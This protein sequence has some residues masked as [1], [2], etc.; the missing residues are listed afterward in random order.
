MASSIGPLT[1][2]DE[3]DYVE[4]WL[5]CFAAFARVKEWQ[6]ER[7][8]D[9][10]N[11]ITN[12]FMASAGCEAIMKIKVI[13]YP[14]VLEKMTFREIEQA[15]RKDVRPKK[16]LVIAERTKFLSTK[17]NPGE[18]ARNYVHRLKQA[19]RFCEFEKLGSGM[20]STEEELIQLRFIEGLHE[21]GQKDKI[22][23]RLQSSDMGLEHCI[24]FVQQ[25][26]LISNFK[27]EEKEEAMVFQMK[28]TAEKDERIQKKKQTKNSVRC[29]YCNFIH[30]TDRKLNCPAFGKTCFVCNRLNHF[31][32][33]CEFKQK[34]VD[35]VEDIFQIRTNKKKRLTVT[36]NN[37]QFPMQPDTGS[38][39]T[40][41][42][43]NF[44]KKLGYPKLRKS[45]V[46]LRQFDGSCINALGQFEAV[47]EAEKRFELVS[48]TVV[49][50]FKDHGLIGTDI[51]KVDTINLINSV[52]SDK[53]K[54]GV[55]KNYKAT[56]RVKENCSPSYFEARRIPI[57]L[58]PMV[59]KKLE[60]MINQGILEHV[61]KG[62]SNWAS[63]IVVLKKKDG[64]LRICGDY[65]V[66]VNH[67]IC[68]DSYP[69]PNVETILHALAGSKYFTKI[70][71][72]S[73]YNQIQIDENF[74]EITTINTPIGLLRWCRMPYG[75][76]TASSIF[77]RAIENVLT[78]EV[79]KMVIYQDDI[80]VGAVNMDE[81]RRKTQRILKKLEDAGMSI[82]KEKCKFNCESI[83]YLGL[84][85]SKDGISPD[86][87]L[88]NKIA[89]VSTPTN[90]KD[91]ESFLGLV[92]FYSRY[93]HKYSD[94]VEPFSEVRKKNT[95]FVWS[96]KLEAAFCKLK[97]A[98]MEKPVVKVFDPKKETTLTTDASGKA[99]SA[100]LSQDN[101]PF[102]YL[103]RKLTKAE[104]NYSNIEKEALAIVWSTQRARQFL[105]GHKFLLKSD[106]RPLEF[107]FNP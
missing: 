8:D 67:K 13:V 16:K 9:G 57:H 26:E 3:P 25:L 105:L 1:R 32:S 82:N 5:E 44:W 7:R 14:R 33:V 56:L 59:I 58:R 76:K 60:E 70:D 79:E 19:S 87:N 72:K 86:Q 83:N 40:I 52:E 107:I 81:L 101:H 66:G 12:H 48:I 29:K 90:K 55:L 93:L 22:L 2:L 89:R 43:K 98:L 42:P 84:Q 39:V 24:E 96:P 64:D 97:N 85:I 65:K 94:L 51:I 103:S 102:M 15:I 34:Q 99:V 17:Q 61:P 38:D 92:N 75:I 71:L 62:G 45:C 53:Q 6:D 31:S 41:I 30:N 49:D 36:L 18:T 78:G 20:M 28:E 23:E 95:E 46:K 69:I 63:P 37:I 27:K 54:I 91:L 47:F 104:M 74:Q 80:L 50:C 21:E 11:E 106:H 4:T 68:A 10:T 77:Q 73:A 35:S 88:L 100:I